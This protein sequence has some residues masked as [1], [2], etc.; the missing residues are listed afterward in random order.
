MPAK[1]RTTLLLVITLLSFS[2]HFFQHMSYG[3]KTDKIVKKSL[4]IHCLMPRTK[5]ATQPL[6][7]SSNTIFSELSDK[8][9]NVKHRI[10]CAVTGTWSAT[11]TVSFRTYLLKHSYK[12]SNRTKCIH[13][14]LPP[15]T[16]IPSCQLPQKL[17]ALT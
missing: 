8:T 4:H 7:L 1:K 5:D 10:R 14:P 15:P 13:A 6:L 2:L 3:I 9:C 16:K 11:H 17:P 12:I